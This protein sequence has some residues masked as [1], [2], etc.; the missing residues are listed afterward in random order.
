MKL[1]F[2]WQVLEDH[3]LEIDLD[4]LF[5][6]LVR[7]GSLDGSEPRT[8]GTLSEVFRDGGEIEQLLWISQG[9]DTIV[10]QHGREL[11]SHPFA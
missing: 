10:R 2:E 3:K 8:L 11:T 5:D 4:D 7:E 1:K 6:W 9:K